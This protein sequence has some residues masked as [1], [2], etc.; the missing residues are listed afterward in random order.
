MIKLEEQAEERALQPS[1]IKNPICPFCSKEIK[2]IY[3]REVKSYLGKR[4]VYYCSDW[5]KVLGFSH[6][7]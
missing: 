7:K 6:R 1:G 4:C 3:M 2:K 5:L